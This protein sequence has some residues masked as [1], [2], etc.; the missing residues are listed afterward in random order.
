MDQP[1]SP[2]PV[3]TKPPAK[4]L[5][6]TA[7][8]ALTVTGLSVVLLAA[9]CAHHQRHHGASPE[10]M[11]AEMKAKDLNGDS[12]LTWKEFSAGSKRHHSKYMHKHFDNIDT[13]ADGVVSFAEL[14]A[15]K[16]H[17]VGHHKG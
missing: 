17:P 3:S 16:H 5:S 11:R 8:V 13:N 4:K 1:A 15:A 2:E 14:D 10:Q 12:Q 7:K 6:T 9:G